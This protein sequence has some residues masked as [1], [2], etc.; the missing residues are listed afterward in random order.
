SIY[1]MNHY[2]G[3][4]PLN[5]GGGSDISI[6]DLAYL[7]KDIVGYTG[8][9]WF[10]TDRP[11]GM[12]IKILD[13]RILQAL[14]WQPATDFQTG[15]LKTYDWFLSHRDDERAHLSLRTSLNAHR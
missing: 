14:G 9:L 12:P 4:E 8:A 5:L 2:D 10:N 11:D 7:I 15:L 13:S 1:A 6:R 3:I